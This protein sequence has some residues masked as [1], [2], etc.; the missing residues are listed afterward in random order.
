LNAFP[1]GADVPIIRCPNCNDQVEI[2]DDWYGRRIA[3]PNCDE[4]FTPRRSRDDD[5][6]RPSSRRRAAYD[7]DDRPRRRSRYDAD[8]RPAKKGNTVL[9][10]VLSL[11]GVFVVLPCVGCVGFVIYV[12]TAKETFD[13]SWTDQSVAA[14]GGPAVTASFPKSPVS[15]ALMDAVNNGNG[16]ALGYS[17]MDQG[18]SIK[19]AIFVIGYVDYPAGTAN[20]L[21]RGYLA[22]RKQ[23]EEAYMDNPLVPP[24]VASERGTTVGGYPAKEATYSDEDGSYTLRVIHVNDRPPG[25][26]ARLVVVAAGG[27]GMKDEDKQKFLN[28]VKI[29]GRK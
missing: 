1:R 24:T 7:D 21:D 17:N 14:G 11:V 27:T 4:K 5:G 20:P 3:C 19:D 12:N 2:E 29:S 26:P 28:S 9:W 13:G 15:R 16:T 23:M 10:V 18:G 6:D 8:D 22:V 25:Q